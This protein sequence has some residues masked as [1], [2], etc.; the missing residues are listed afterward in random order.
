MTVLLITGGGGGGG[1]TTGSAG[2]TSVVF[3]FGFFFFFDADVGRDSACSTSSRSS[4]LFSSECMIDVD[5]NNCD[6]SEDVESFL[7][8]S[9][10]L[11]SSLVNDGN[12][13]ESVDVLLV[14]ARLNC[15]NS[16]T[17]SRVSCVSS[18]ACRS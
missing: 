12:N 4:T 3:C 14:N 6:A 1:S 11:T 2:K 15:A 9:I 17:L 7:A 16:C 8:S 18:N 10:C 5:D 13:S